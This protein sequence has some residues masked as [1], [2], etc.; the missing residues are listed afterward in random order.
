MIKFT[1]YTIFRRVAAAKVTKVRGNLVGTEGTQGNSAK[2]LAN[3]FG[4]GQSTRRSR[5]HVIFG[6][7][8]G[9]DVVG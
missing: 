1:D 2:L 6:V 8:K 9:Q 5:A 7:H 3:R 4:Q